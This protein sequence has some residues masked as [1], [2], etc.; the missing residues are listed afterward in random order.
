MSDYR[1]GSSS[2]PEQEAGPLVVG[3]VS[4]SDD[5]RTSI[6]SLGDRS[7][8]LTGI[9]PATGAGSEVSSYTIDSYDNTLE[10]EILVHSTCLDI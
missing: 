5:P 10:T 1:G 2:S 3:G 8:G 4:Q 9:V 6:I 7:R